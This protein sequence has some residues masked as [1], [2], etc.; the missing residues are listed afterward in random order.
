MTT[1]LLQALN[2]AAKEAGF[3]GFFGRAKVEEYLKH[4][5]SVI[6]KYR[7]SGLSDKEILKLMQ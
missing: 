4:L 5:E 6:E 1:N 3:T 2:K 7:S